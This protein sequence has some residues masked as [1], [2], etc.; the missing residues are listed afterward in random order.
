VILI[1]AQEQFDLQAV[2]AFAS[3]GGDELVGIVGVGCLWWGQL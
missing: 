1:R 3:E 2:Y